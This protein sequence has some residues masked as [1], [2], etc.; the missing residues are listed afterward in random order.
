MYKIIHRLLPLFVALLALPLQG[1]P[2]RESIL[3]ATD[4][5][6]YL[7]GEYLRVSL[8]VTMPD[9]ANRPS[10]SRV[11]YVEISDTRRMVAQAMI[12]LEN[13]IGWG[14]IPLPAETQSG[15]YQLTAYTSA[16]RNFGAAAYF[17]TWIGIVNAERVSRWDRLSILPPE[18]DSI[19]EPISRIARPGDTICH[20]LPTAWAEGGYAVS[21]ERADITSN[22]PALRSSI[23]KAAAK[24]TPL[25]AT[26]SYPCEAEGHIVTV[27]PVYAEATGGSPKASA[28]TCS[29]ARL[30]L[31]GQR[32]ELFDGRPQPDGSFRF[33][34]SGLY[35]NQPVM[36]DGYSTEG[37]KVEL[38]FRPPYAQSLPPSLPALTIRT[39][40][41]EL[42]T[43][44]LSARRQQ[45]AGEWL[46]R[47]T[48]N[49]LLDFASVIPNRFYDLEEYTRF[50]S[51]REI[52]IEFV[53]GV[54]TRSYRGRKQIYTLVPETNT[55]SSWSA[56][57][58]L[59]GMPIDDID[60]ILD[61][62]ARLIRFVQI[63]HDRFFFGSRCCQGVIAFTTH[64]GRLANYQLGPT[65][66]LM[67]YAFPQERPPFAR[68]AA[69]DYET[70]YWNPCAQGEVRIPAPDTP[71]RYRILIQGL[72]EGEPVRLT[73][74]FEVR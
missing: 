36:V 44:A 28:D 22:L 65:L 15:V 52:L 59:D 48:L 27:D 12:A 26:D 49:H 23:P 70:L 57:V 60:M 24:P 51:I 71:G 55:Y 25:T 19:A 20:T 50:N 32:A 47:D 18:G 13:G 11:A 63:Y 72:A 74:Y 5:E 66:R 7:T 45:A 33:F 16:M 30:A 37:E 68:L 1:Q 10:P 8:R 62:D 6:C 46:H 58:L 56:L 42:A 38:R 41:K 43:R 17:S 31:V 35:G 3:A 34:T 53:Q 29:D 54:R 67:S 21:V 61:Y 9:A 14:E 4:R 39:D 73:E 2:L 40:E 69:D 64:K